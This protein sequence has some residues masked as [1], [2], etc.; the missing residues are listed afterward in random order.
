MSIEIETWVDF[1]F[2]V[3][4]IPIGTDSRAPLQ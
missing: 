4:V 3:S 2:I 1:G